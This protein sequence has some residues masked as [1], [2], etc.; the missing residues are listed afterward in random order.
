MSFKPF[1]VNT[2]EDRVS[3]LQG[4]A[5][6]TLSELPFE[7][8][9]IQDPFGLRK[10]VL[11]VFKR[12]S[13][14]E[15]CGM[16]TAFHID[17]WGTFL[18]ADHVIDFAR[19]HPKSTSCWTD[20]S[21]NSNGDHPVLFL[22]MGLVF[23]TVNIPKESFAFVKHIVSALREKDDPLL[24]LKGK[25]ESEN[26]ADLA[27]LTAVFEPGV[28][29]P[30]SVPVKGSG[31]YPQIGE[32]VL[33]IGFPELGFDENILSEGMY[34][35]YGRIKEI[36]PHGTNE[37][38]PTPVFEVECNWLSG[39]SGGP[40][41]NMSGEVVGLV[42][43]SLPPDGDLPGSGMA[44]YFHLIHY[45]DELVPTLDSLNPGWRKGWAVLRSEPWHLAGFFKTKA[46]AVELAKAMSS[47]YQVKYGSNNFGTDD[48]IS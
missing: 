29:M 23:G 47:D 20:V 43:R 10:A 27:V 31:W 18:S 21:L 42:S 11:P 38:H 34:G 7:P 35:A 40:V 15:L 41:F 8:F 16:G 25:T 48:F 13:N 6:D 1:Y 4:I 46:E 17:G 37:S 24:S 32:W 2:C 39:M 26:A 5:F 22:G 3:N 36:H 44:T 30:H 19:E 28:K 33:A 14:G 9:L 45:F 12:D